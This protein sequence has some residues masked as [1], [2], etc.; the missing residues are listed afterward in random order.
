MLRKIILEQ[1]RKKA[2]CIEEET[3]RLGLEFKMVDT[4]FNP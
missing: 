4:Q 3:Y 2:E 1:C